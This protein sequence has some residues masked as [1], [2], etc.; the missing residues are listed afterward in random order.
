MSLPHERESLALDS[1]HD[2]SE[3]ASYIDRR[4]VKLSQL[5]RSL[6]INK[7]RENNE[8]M[9]VE[10]NQQASKERKF[11]QTAKET[12]EYR[13]QTPPLLESLYRTQFRPEK[14][15]YNQSIHDSRAYSELKSEQLQKNRNSFD[16]ATLQS[17]SGSRMLQ[18]RN[19]KEKLRMYQD[20]KQQMIGTFYVGTRNS[21]AKGNL[22]TLPVRNS[23]YESHDARTKRGKLW[24]GRPPVKIIER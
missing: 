2:I 24:H 5:Y 9:L 12:F 8:S 17:R 7:K 20:V 14:K 10:N 1:L 15:R 3:Y 19:N 11:Y 23:E 13:K 21:P 22:K 16:Y 6:D 18:P 4:I